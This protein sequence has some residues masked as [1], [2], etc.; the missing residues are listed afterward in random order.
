MLVQKASLAGKDE[1]R[2]LARDPSQRTMLGS[3]NICE[4]NKQ[5]YKNKTN[6]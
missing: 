4:M 1:A 2:N 6:K 5:S 3:I